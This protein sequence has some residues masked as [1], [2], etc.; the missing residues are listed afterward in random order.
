MSGAW[1]L[2]RCASYDALGII[3]ITVRGRGGNAE[4]RQ[5]NRFLLNYLCG[6]VDAHDLVTDAWNE[7]EVVEEAQEIL[8][9]ARK[10]KD[11][12]KVA[13]GRR[14]R[15]NENISRGTLKCT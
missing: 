10:A 13:Y 15:R 2:P 3:R 14:T 5:P 12:N 11:R 1:S 4:H 6:A 9:A 7:I 8:R